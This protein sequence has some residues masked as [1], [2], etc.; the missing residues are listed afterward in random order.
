MF[1]IKDDYAALMK[2][3][4]RF[5]VEEHGA[6]VVLFPHVF[7]PDADPESDPAACRALLKDLGEAF[8]G[9]VQVV[10]ERLDQSEMKHLLG[11]CDFFLG[12]RMHACIGAI[13]KGVPTIGLAYSKKFVGVFRTIGA[14]DK[15]VDL[16]RADNDEVMRRVK[17]IFDHR[18]AIRDSLEARMPAVKGEIALL[19][20]KIT[21][22]DLVPTA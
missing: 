10:Q 12:S 1:G 2:R 14:E 21:N 17:E 6:R 13:S 8:E 7:A 3:L 9:R 15:V 16:R 22:W 20:R 19:I 5:F 11:E 4:V 18:R